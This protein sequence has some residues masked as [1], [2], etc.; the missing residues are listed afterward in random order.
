MVPK[1][2]A[3]PLGPYAL[4]VPDA[5]LQQETDGVEVRERWGSGRSSGP[6]PRGRPERR[7]SFRPKDARSDGWG[8]RSQKEVR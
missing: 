2:L 6:S 8:Q 4:H 1:V 5:D 7:L 3:C